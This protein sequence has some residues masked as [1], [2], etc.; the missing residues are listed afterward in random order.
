MLHR[1]GSSIF[2]GPGFDALARPV[3]P[4]R[5]ATS[6]F[7]IRPRNQLLTPDKLSATN[8]VYLLAGVYTGD[9]GTRCPQNWVTHSMM[10]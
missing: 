2:R 6:E 8:P 7:A 9:I 1:C 4:L 10:A 3:P 5:Y